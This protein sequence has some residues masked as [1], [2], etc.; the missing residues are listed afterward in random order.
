MDDFIIDEYAVETVWKNCGQYWLS[1][2]TGKLMN[3]DELTD[4]NIPDNIT[5]SQFLVNM[6]YIPYVSVSE[7]ELIHAFIP[8]LKNKKLSQAL[9]NISDD[10]LCESFWK[11][12]NAYEEISSS[13][14]QFEKCY[15]QQKVVNWCIENGLKYLIK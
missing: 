2:K 15:V 6:G 8:T 3:C 11:Y 7:N 4:L 9:T 12:L 14:G 10:C 13:Y 5:Q 1:T